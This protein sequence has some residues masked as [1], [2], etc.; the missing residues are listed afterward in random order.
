M[1]CSL[2][3]GVTP[4]IAISSP[5]L[6]SAGFTTQSPSSPATVDGQTVSGNIVL[7][8]LRSVD[9]LSH[10]NGNRLDCT[11]IALAGLLTRVPPSATNPVHWD[12]VRSVGNHSAGKNLTRASRR[13]WA[14]DDEIVAPF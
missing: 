8:V 1:S 6:P 12:F 2:R 11:N 13:P 9:K 5:T 10:T 7:H 14:N 4:A 3:S